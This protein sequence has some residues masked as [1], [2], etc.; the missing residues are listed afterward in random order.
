MRFASSREN[1]GYYHDPT[2]KKDANQALTGTTLRVYRF[3]LISSKP[4]SAR[5]VQRALG[6]SGASVATFHLEK[7][8]RYCLAKRDEVNGTYVVDEV[9]LKHFVLWKRHLIPRYFFFAILASFSIIGWL[10]PL[11]S[12]ES[13]HY[14]LIYGLSFSILFSVIFWRETLDVVRNEKL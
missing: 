4:A 8:E 1:T 3:L 5:D 2:S 14:A 9:Y 10:P 6:L 13:P 7:L 11:L 12:N